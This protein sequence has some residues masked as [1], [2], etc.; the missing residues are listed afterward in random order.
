[1]LGPL[2]VVR[3]GVSID[4]LG[5]PE[6][7]LLA[8][9]ALRPGE[10][11]S[12][13]ELADAVWGEVLPD[14]P[15][16]A[17]QARV[18]R[19]RKAL[20]GE[21][22]RTTSS[23][24]ALA[25]DPS[26]VD[27]RRFE[28][29]L[30][31]ARSEAEPARREAAIGV[32]LDLW[33]GPAL[34]EF[35]QDEF[36][37]E[38]VRRLD[39][40]RT[41]AE[42]ERIEAALEAGR[43]R[44]VLAAVETLVAVRPLDEA[45]RQLHMLALY[46]V[47]RHADALASY[48]E[49]RR[50]LG[51][52]L[53]L[54]PSPGLRELEER[55]LLHDPALGT[56]AR[57]KPSGNLPERL[58]SF[59]GRDG[60]IVEV[61]RLLDEG[62]LVT[63]TGPGGAGK[64]SL[65]V[66]TA[67]RRS[68][69]HPDGAWLVELAAV[70]GGSGVLDAVAAA[71]DIDRSPGFRSGAETER[72]LE[73]AIVAHLRGR[74]ALVILDNCEHVV[75]ASARLAASILTRCPAVRILATSREQLDVPGEVVWRI[76]PLAADDG[77]PGRH[78]PANRLFAE[79]AAAAGGARTFSGEEWADIARI[80]RRLDGLPLAIELAAART[81]SL[82][83][84]DLAARLD[85][86]L[87]LLTTGS[88]LAGARQQTLRATIDWSHRLLADDEQA[89]FRRLAMF[90]G[91]F[92]LEAAE[93][94]AAGPEVAS[95]PVIDVI[96]RLVGQ[97]MVVTHLGTFSLLETIRDF[98]RERLAE[99]GEV[100][101]TGARLLRHTRSM[102][103]TVEAELR[104]AAQLDVLAQLDAT[105]PNIRSALEWSAGSDPEGGLELVVEL[106]WY[107]YVRGLRREGRRWAE[108]LL[109]EVGAAAPTRLR[110]R[111]L[112]LMAIAEPQWTSSVDLMDEALALLEADPEEWHTAVVRCFASVFGS[113]GRDVVVA[114][115]LLERSRRWFA[116]QND[117]WG[118]GLCDLLEGALLGAAGDITAAAGLLDAAVEGFRRV[119]DLWGE[120]YGEF[121]AGMGARIVGHYERASAAYEAAAAKA[122]LLGMPEEAVMIV[123]DLGNVA[124][125]RGEH[126][127]AAALIAEAGRR[128]QDVG[129]GQAI[130]MVENAS[131]L[132][133]RRE[134]RLAEA[135]RHHE[136]AVEEY[137]RI[138]ADG[139]VAYAAGSM[140]YVAALQGDAAASV[141][142]AQTSLDAAER[143]GDLLGIAFAL[144]AGA[145]ALAASGDPGVASRLLGAA[146]AIRRGRG[147]PMPPAERW[148]VD[149]AVAVAREDLGASGYDEAFAS[150]S[151]L[152]ADEAA[153]LMRTSAAEAS[154]RR[155]G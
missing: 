134:G 91:R 129:T 146:D 12:V 148:D 79:R 114:G 107:W 30:A 106:T 108:L 33:R 29:A 155:P 31:A 32:A 35:R 136:R 14:N 116:A 130:G 34:A 110:G 85:D 4:L 83:V 37:Q 53:G 90:G 147:L 80:V 72:S 60:E 52:E 51:E 36:A 46:G 82:G 144:E 58:T 117:E 38:A 150:G 62:R 139:G 88:R 153:A 5:L 49:A 149:H 22:I 131:G 54:E 15:R 3:D 25:V 140:A 26:D 55:I 96:D 11:V 48:Q 121:L 50:L 2:L 21:T 1:M 94:V 154:R 63:I 99:H 102:V 138:G 74:T 17:I 59:V 65:A 44:D 84:A 126:G 10:P 127:K 67:R 123:T 24:Y 141:A 87:G 28:D 115:H 86:A 143:D 135:R 13:E 66:E 124:T 78:G 109:D 73:D 7:Q 19:L 152:G 69:R 77:L 142:A 45:V 145:A 41:T 93:A 137:R 8:A 101:T 42:V 113:S 68:E 95:R 71:L 23:G 132:L 120:G 105:L 61:D 119:G 16:N 103:T 70:G 118:Q 18:S 20:G 75:M 151:R 104:T 128:A 122:E 89:V 98:A 100:D 56:P 97:S 92:G 111:A 125:L 64:T 40:L 81:R 6:R 112:A 27:V 39:A 9:L 47:G 57:T 133:A 76:P 43:H